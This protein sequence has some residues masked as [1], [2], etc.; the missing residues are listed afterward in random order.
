MDLIQ[1]NKKINFDVHNKRRNIFLEEIR[2]LY[3]INVFSKCFEIKYSRNLLGSKYDLTLVTFTVIHVLI[4]VR[5]RT[6]RIL[7]GIW[8]Y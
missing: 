8:F 4:R 2:F 7:A 5:S 6:P 3:A 1:Y